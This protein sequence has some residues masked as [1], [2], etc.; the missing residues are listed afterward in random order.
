MAMSLRTLSAFVLA[1]AVAG[2]AP[3]VARE[4]AAG[5]VPIGQPAA[6][7]PGQMFKDCA[8]CPELVVVPAGIFIMGLNAAGNRSKPPHR[9]NIKKP[10]AMG[11]FEVTWAE[12]EACAKAKAC[13]SGGDDDHGWGKE[14]RPVINV[15]WNDTKLYL[16]WLAKKTGKKYRLPSEAEWEYADRAGTT[17]QWWWGNDKGEN[18]ANCKDCKSKW[19]AWSSA[20]VG[21]FKAN[22]F[23]LYDTTANLFEWVEDCWNGSHKGAP[24][25]G[26]ARTRG[27]CNN[28]VIRGGSFYYFSKV[29][30]SDYRAKNPPS[31]KSYWLGFRVLRDID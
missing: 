16:G 23:G 10:F 14:G 8:E 9:V 27:D 26:S 2:A 25:D 17:T 28:R 12:W 13:T 1:L 31:V 21:S 7:K 6:V 22:P 11:R 20:P 30:M 24:G 29:A 5:K 18:N 19:S 3:A 4:P 15:T